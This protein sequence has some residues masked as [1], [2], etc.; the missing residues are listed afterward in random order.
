[1]TNQIELIKELLNYVE[2]Y[3]NTT[4]NI[5]IN[6]FSHF[7]IK[8]ISLGNDINNENI[9]LKRFEKENYN[10]YKHYSEVEFSTLLTNL[11][12]FAKHYIKKA[13]K[14][15]EIKT[16]DEFGFLA[17]LLRQKSLL[18][19]DLINEH[20]LETSSGSEILKRLKLKELITESTCSTDKRA[21]QVSLTAKGVETIMASFDEMHKVSEIIIGNLTEDELEQSLIIF[22][23]LN[24]FHQ[25]IHRVNKDSSLTKIYLTHINK[26]NP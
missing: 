3:Q 18:K 17:S 7:L 2:K 15:T 11:Y 24:D 10:N 12:R 13:F 26:S 14:N 4:D 6:D 9:S 5:N 19:K 8:Q 21:K 16:I 1:M 20:L 22:N 25:H 23:K